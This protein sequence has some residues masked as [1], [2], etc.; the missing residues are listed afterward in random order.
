MGSQKLGDDTID[1]NPPP[2]KDYAKTDNVRI[3][4]ES[5]TPGLMRPK[6]A[7]TRVINEEEEEEDYDEDADIKEQGL[8]EMIQ[9]HEYYQK[10]SDLLKTTFQK[11]S[12]LLKTSFQ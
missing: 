2:M 12:N 11:A 1:S 5:N 6:P 4:T 7:P 10:A 9:D 8:L 3:Y